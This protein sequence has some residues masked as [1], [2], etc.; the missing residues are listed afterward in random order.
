M[1]Y[2]SAMQI[3]G[4]H[5]SVTVVDEP[6]KQTGPM[7]YIIGSYSPLSRGMVCYHNDDLIDTCGENFTHETVEAINSLYDLKLD[8]QT[9]TTLATALY[10]AFA[11]GE[12]S[13]TKESPC[14]ETTH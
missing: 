10:Q 8:H 11:S 4:N 12:V 2:P 7:S 1:K 14:S 5:V 9:I 3:G 6:I 13:F